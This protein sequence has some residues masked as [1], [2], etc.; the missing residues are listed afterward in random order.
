[1]VGGET[2]MRELKICPFCGRTAEL[3]HPGYEYY[4]PCWC[5][6]TQCGA[7]GPT[8][9]S[10]LEAKE[11]WNRRVKER[12]DRWVNVKDELPE[13]DVDVLV[14]NGLGVEIGAYTTNPIKR[15]YGMSGQIVNVNYWM[16]LSEPPK[17]EK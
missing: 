2:G 15:W 9:V 12:F 5:K 4:S 13:E 10:E 11:A 1:M 6:C 7:E 14:A 17:T 3:K 8:K 16:P